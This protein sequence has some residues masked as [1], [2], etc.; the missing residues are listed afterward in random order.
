LMTSS[1]STKS[2]RFDRMTALDTSA[3]SCCT[4]APHSAKHWLPLSCRDTC[5]TAPTAQ[6]PSTGPHILPKYFFV[7]SHPLLVL[8]RATAAQMVYRLDQES[9]K[10]ET[11]V[12]FLAGE[13]YFSLLYSL[14]MALRPIQ[15]PIQWKMGAL[16]PGVMQLRH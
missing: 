14:Y 8:T 6:V 15:N 1:P 7:T 2:V 11:G 10:Q 4:M 13:K 16:S 5:P 12:R 3:S 9:H